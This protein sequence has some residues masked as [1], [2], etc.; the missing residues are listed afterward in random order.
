MLF[1]L[2]TEVCYYILLNL[3]R[4]REE[5]AE[6]IFPHISTPD[7][8]Y[9][10]EA[11]F[12][13]DA[14]LTWVF[15]QSFQK[16]P[17]RIVATAESLS[18]KI[19]YPKWKEVCL[20][21]LPK[22]PADIFCNTYFKVALTASAI[23]VSIFSIY[24]VHARV[25]HLFAAK[26]IP[27]I[28]NHVPVQV[29]RAGNAIIGA[30]EFV[31]RNYLPI[32]VVTWLIREGIGRLPEIPYLSAAA[33]SIDLRQL[34]NRFTSSPQTIFWFAL[35]RSIS[36]ISSV[37]GVS[38]NIGQRFRKISSNAEKERDIAYRQKSLGVWKNCQVAL[39]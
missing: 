29:I 17:G 4:N 16:N 9:R 28:I 38:Q 34:Y 13:R 22:V 27:F 36:V 35:E 8:R 24:Q 23:F 1:I 39:A 15:N 21:Q 12:K 19:F 30:K 18:N 2:T 25:S 31:W 10:K 5:N 20:I 3:L 33:R 14:V 7:I 11:R 6:E 37:W 26:G 32:I